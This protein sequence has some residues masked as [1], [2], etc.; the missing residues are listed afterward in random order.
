MPNRISIEANDLVKSTMPF[1]VSAANNTH[2][3]G[4]HD[5]FISK[6]DLIEHKRL[7]E[8]WIAT[9]ADRKK[10][11]NDQGLTRDIS[12]AYRDTAGFM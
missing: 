2:L 4:C 5:L 3:Q 6:E 10:S 1:L 8:I 9:K 7:C 12:D 11:R